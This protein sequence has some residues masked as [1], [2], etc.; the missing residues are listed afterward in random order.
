MKRVGPVG[1]ANIL[2]NTIFYTISD[3]VIYVYP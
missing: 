1:R 3:S 2:F